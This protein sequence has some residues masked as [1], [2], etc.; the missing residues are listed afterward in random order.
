MNNTITIH[1]DQNY[2]LRNG[3]FTTNN[4]VQ[5]GDRIH[6]GFDAKQYI[7]SRFL[8]DWKTI[9]EGYKGKLIKQ[10]SAMTPSVW[11]LHP[12]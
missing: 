5:E 12:V 9:P 1:T 2:A 7:N 6:S 8:K 11:E 10:G 4:N 3:N